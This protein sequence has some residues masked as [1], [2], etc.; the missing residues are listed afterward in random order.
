MPSACSRKEEFDRPTLHANSRYIPRRSDRYCSGWSLR[1]C[2]IAPSPSAVARICARLRIKAPGWRGRVSTIG[3]RRVS[4]N[5]GL[6]ERPDAR[7]ARGATRCPMGSRSV[8]VRDGLAERPGTGWARGAT[9]NG[10][11][12]RSDPERD[13]LAE[14]PGT[15]WA[16]GATRNGMGSRSDPERDGLA[17]RPGTGWARG[18]TRNGMGSRSD[19]ERDGLAERPG[20]GWARG[21]TRC[22]MP[23][24][25]RH[26]HQQ[27]LSHLSTA[28]VAPLPGARAGPRRRDRWPTVRPARL[29]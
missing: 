4:R 19:P 18:A 12:S 5:D 15:G 25:R 10:M 20:T 8:P 1:P 2:Q 22:P 21:A 27:R 6:A 14:R 3:L 7:W 26:D 29:V 17:E 9:R 16:R 24:R 11:G 13:G 23:D 28:A